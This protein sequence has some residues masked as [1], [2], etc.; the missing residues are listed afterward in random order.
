MRILTNK[1]ALEIL[2]HRWTKLVNPYCTDE[3][4][5]Q[6]LDITINALQKE[7]KKKR[8]LEQI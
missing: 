4:L 8:T 6:A 7:T 3:E 5:K 1:Q 2:E